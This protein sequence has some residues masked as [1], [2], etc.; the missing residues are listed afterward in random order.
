M[1]AGVICGVSAVF[2]P[3]DIS[4]IL[5]VGAFSGCFSSDLPP[6]S[7]YILFRRVLPLLALGLSG[8]GMFARQC[9][10]IL[11]LGCSA[12]AAARSACLFVFAGGG[13]RSTF[14]YALYCF[15]EILA[16]TFI[17]SAARLAL[18]FSRAARRKCGRGLVLR[19]MLDVSFFI[20]M[21]VLSELPRSYAAAAFV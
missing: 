15:S 13:A 1:P 18:R 5:P 17:A 9:G 11:L 7:L 4:D 14:I 8:F 3:G 10:A 2:L 19:Y 20:G 16:L 21:V 12:A 6:V